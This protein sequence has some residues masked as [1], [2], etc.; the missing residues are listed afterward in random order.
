MILLKDQITAHFR[1]NEFANNED[2]GVIEVTPSFVQF[3]L[4]LEEFRGWYNRPVLI[5]SGYRTKA[6]NK[7]VGGV[8]NSLHLKGLAVDFALPSAFYN[9]SKAR[10]NQF[11]ENIKNKWYEICDENGIFGSVLYYDRWVHLDVRT[12]KRYFEDKRGK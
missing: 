1:L 2:G 4:M 9:Y 12:N 10:Q 8:S 7:K 6:F 5:T 11:L 3:V